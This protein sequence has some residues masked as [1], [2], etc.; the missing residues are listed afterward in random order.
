M[1]IPTPMFLA[2]T[3][4]KIDVYNGLTKN[5]A[6]KVELSFEG[7]CRYEDSFETITLADG[8]KVKT[9]GT[10]FVFTDFAP[11]VA[12]ITGGK[13]IVN[14]LS[15]QIASAE[16]NRNPDGSFNHYELRLM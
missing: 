11:S 6:D 4:V 12:K 2:T 3:P 8:R 9:T 5:G 10:I 14:G 16:K 13:V 1:R 15:C 7:S